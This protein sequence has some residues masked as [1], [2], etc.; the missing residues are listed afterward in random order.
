MSTDL[1]QAKTASDIRQTP[2]AS[3]GLLLPCATVFLSGFCLMVVELVAGGLVRGYIGSSLYTWTSIIGVILGGITIGNYLGGRLA[4]RYESRRLVMTLFFVS[5]V[6]CLLIIPVVHLIG[7]ATSGWI[8]SDNIWMARIFTVITVSFL[9]PGTAMGTISPP[10]AKWAL[11]HG[12]ATGKTVGSVYAWNTFGSIVGTFV[13]GF[14]LSAHFGVTTIVVMAG[15]CLGLIGGAF[16]VGILLGRSPTEAPPRQFVE[17]GPGHRRMAA[18]FLPCLLVFMS[19]FAVMLVE[20]VASRFTASAIGQSVY[21]WT[22]VIGVVLAGICI[23]NY[24][25]GQMADRFPPKP[26]VGSLFLVA[27]F[28]CL[29]IL[30][31]SNFINN[32]SKAWM[33]SLP[34]SIRV[35]LV[36]FAAF[37]FAATSLGTISPAVAKWALERGY[38]TGRTV[39]T[40]YAWNTVGSIIGTFATGFFL[41]STFYASRLIVVTSL[42]LALLAFLF[43]VISGNWT[44][45]FLSMAWIIIVGFVGA[46][47]VMPADRFGETLLTVLPV[48]P[49]Q[50]KTIEE[51]RGDLTSAQ[52]RRIVLAAMML[53]RRNEINVRDGFEELSGSYYDESNYYTIR[54]DERQASSADQQ[55]T[56]DDDTEYPERTVRTLS[57]D[58]LLH[59]FFD[60]KD[61][62]Y[63]QYE[64]EHIYAGIG[65]RLLKRHQ[66]EGKRLKVLFLGGGSYTFQRYL[67]Q[68]FSD[69]D[70]VV[71]EIDP[72]VTAAVR[73]AIGLNRA[74]GKRFLLISDVELS[75]PADRPGVERNGPWPVFVD[76]PPSFRERLEMMAQAF[77]PADDPYRLYQDWR[78]RIYLAGGILVDSM[79]QQPDYVLHLKGDASAS[80]PVVAKAEEQKVPVIGP[81]DFE[82]LIAE[83][84]YENITTYI[85][86]AREYVTQATEEG[87]F[88]IVYA[89]AFNDFSVPAHLTTVEFNRKLAKLLKPDGIF[90]GNVIDVW[91]LSRFMGSYYNT[92]KEIFPH[93]HVLSTSPGRQSSTRMTFV[94]VASREPIDLEELG[95]RAGEEKFVG[96]LIEGPYLQPILRGGMERLGECEFVSDGERTEYELPHKAFAAG[97]RLEADGQSVDLLDDEYVVVEES[98]LRLSRAPEAGTKINVRMFGEDKIILTDDYCP[99]DNFLSEVISTRINFD[100]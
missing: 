90:M 34:W 72:R 79:D 66:Q 89:D 24:V 33:G 58:A 17:S 48:Y 37:F 75:P 57:L 74:N 87:T 38:A 59:G 4:D 70:C 19:G 35:F 61:P 84:P 6:T 60:M 85:G 73:K 63:L 92:L 95:K 86:D 55:H 27:S 5:S 51:S 88:D 13:T 46:F 16:L 32:A 9:I 68:T 81:E 80:N 64:Y 65:N 96:Y 98:L 42:V 78:S 39:G 22:S 91:Q 1:S 83:S 52:A 99:V 43:L 50:G 28:F 54:V 10:V 14:Y 15:I 69:I 93:I 20:L 2:T 25:G 7:S 100:N 47:V 62:S 36:V 82:K 71:S 49:D 31:G 21:T 97:V 76:R 3:G 77:N 26:L 18:L 44:A 45:R 29:S 67:T 53:G 8:G 41:I 30:P 94:I 11:D 12:Y 23:G 56:P 40:I